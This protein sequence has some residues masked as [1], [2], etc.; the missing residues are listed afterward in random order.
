VTSS[1]SW[2]PTRWRTT[3]LSTDDR[4]A[5]ERAD[6]RPQHLAPGRG[7]PPGNWSTSTSRSSP[8]RC[9]PCAR[10]SVRHRAHRRL[11][12]RPTPARG[13]PPLC[14]PHRTPL[15]WTRWPVLRT[16]QAVPRSAAGI[17]V[18]ALFRARG[19]GS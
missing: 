19:P 2:L 15:P 1:F 13:V 9:A 7:W 17:R 16:G 8:R 14:R 12:S 6:R 4:A 18:P 10:R 3:S 11:I 5:P